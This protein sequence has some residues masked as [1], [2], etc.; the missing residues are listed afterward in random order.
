ME[1]KLICLDMDGTLLN[2]E[3]TISIRNKEAIKKAHDKGVKIAIC[4]GRLF[5]SA[6]YYANLIGIKAPII[7][8]NGS[9]IREKDRDE[10]IY[11]SLLNK[12]DCQIIWSI[13]KKYDFLSCFNTYDTIISNKPFSKGDFY[14]KINDSL[15][16]NMKIK[17]KV[18]PEF[19]GAFSNNDILKFICL[20]KDYDNLR[21]AK[22]EIKGLNKFEVVSSSINNFEIINKNSSKGKAVEVLAGFYDLKKEEI[23]C[24]GDNEND[25]S[26]IE[27]AGMG[28]AMGNAEEFVKSKA[29]FITD[30]NNNDGIAKVIEKFIL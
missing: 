21:K 29:N 14:Y 2:D 26:M 15:P 8:S 10:V 12:E 27:Y 4:T 16:D 17:L 18:L 23:M 5:I 25:L 3:K 6:K 11:Q 24:I 9:Y 19:E 20:S 22:E 13:I 7:A 1:Y 30:T 28:V